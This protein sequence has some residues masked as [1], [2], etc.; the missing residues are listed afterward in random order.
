MDNLMS[1]LFKK[2][3]IMNQYDE[4]EK[5]YSSLKSDEDRVKFT[6]NIF[7]KNDIKF[8]IKGKEKN[9]SVAA[10]LN[11]QLKSGQKMDLDEIIKMYT[12]T[13]AVAP[14]NSCELSSA[15][16]NRSI[17]LFK[18]RLYSDCIND[19][20]RAL[21]MDY[22]EK[23]K[24]KL[25]ARKARCLMILNPE[26]AAQ[27]IQDALEET[28]KWLE[29]MDLNDNGINFVRKTVKNPEKLVPAKKEFKK[30]DD[31][32][33]LPEIPNDNEEI[34][35]ASSAIKLVYSNKFGRHIVATRDIKPGEILAVQQA[36]VSN[37][38]PEKFYTHCIY[39]LKQTWAGIPCD[40]CAYAIYCSE[41]C[42]QAAWSSHHEIECQVVGP[43][44][45]MGMNNLGL[46]SLRLLISAVKEAGDLK[47]LK[48][49]LKKIDSLTDPRTRGFTGKILDDKKYASVYTLETNTT[50]RSV[51][52]LFG[53]SLNASYITYVLAK[54]SKIFGD[55]LSG[56]L[57][58]LKEHRWF[59]FIGGLI[60]RHQQIIPSNTHLITE[61]NMSIVPY[62]R[63][64]V[65]LP[66]NSYFNH[67][68][69]PSVDLVEF[70]KN[71]ATVAT[72]A[73]KKNEQIFDN[74]GMHYIY[75]P[76]TWLRQKYLKQRFFFDC[77]CEA[78]TNGCLN[79]YGPESY[80]FNAFPFLLSRD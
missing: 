78:C 61:E 38:F 29:K 80:L 6:I 68:C 41:T 49:H 58:D 55:V 51:D 24:A 11:S 26:N 48:N 72:R 62:E 59:T 46:M 1:T 13:I 70:G 8:E 22:P 69:N 66:S 50:K 76:D 12:L 4:F 43:L 35:G 39:C 74:Y 21:A 18:A 42:R 9:K 14:A 30:L 15:Y 45:A 2:L 73:I 34:P 3:K 5:K 20:E 40:K 56:D 60:M 7:E 37:L 53:R 54:K 64:A 52:D 27:K 16:A 47:S 77:K 44:I 23:S 57:I 67:S 65:I 79:F 31:E 17:A 63:A 28:T 32:R 19:I 33:N 75:T 36:Y 71:K 25:Y 10:K